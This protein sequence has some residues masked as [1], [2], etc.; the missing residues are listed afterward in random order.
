[1]LSIAEFMV[2]A[3]HSAISS[4]HQERRTLEKPGAEVEDSLPTFAHSIHLM[5]RI[6]MQEKG[7]KEQRQ[8]PVGKKEYQNRSHFLSLNVIELENKVRLK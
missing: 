3:V 6:S 5:G 2:H 7:V 1:M 8:K 4:W